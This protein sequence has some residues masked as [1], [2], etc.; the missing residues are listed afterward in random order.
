MT[1]CMTPP[2]INHEETKEMKK[3]QKKTFVPF[4]PFV[5][6][7]LIFIVSHASL[8]ATCTTP[9]GFPWLFGT[10]TVTVLALELPETS[11]LSTVIV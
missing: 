9:Q 8:T 10:E 3:D 1:T 2:K 5:S 11:R 4:V 6:S 7:W